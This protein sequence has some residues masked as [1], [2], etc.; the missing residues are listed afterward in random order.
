M[1]P[2]RRRGSA[3]R[4][5]IEASSLGTPRARAV[6]LTVKPAVAASLVARSAARGQTRIQSAKNKPST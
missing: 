1:T 2:P 6:R 5:L 3:I 4:E